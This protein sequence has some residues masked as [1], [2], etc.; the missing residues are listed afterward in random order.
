MYV[1]LSEC[2]VDPDEVVMRANRTRGVLDPDSKK[3]QFR[4]SVDLHAAHV[5]EPTE[6]LPH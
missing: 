5:S 2:G 6:S 3:G 4:E 1:R